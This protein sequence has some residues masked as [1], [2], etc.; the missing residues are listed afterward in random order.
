MRKNRRG[1]FRF[2]IIDLRMMPLLIWFT[3]N[4]Q[5]IESV[6]YSKTFSDR[7]DIK[8]HEISPRNRR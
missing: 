8:E 1:R 3:V 4:W 5:E 6:N 7:E 2:N